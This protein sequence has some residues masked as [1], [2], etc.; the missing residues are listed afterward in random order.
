MLGID[1]LDD[2]LL[3]A[4]TLTLTK[5]FHTDPMYERIFPGPAERSGALSHL[6]RVGLRY[7]LRRGHVTQSDAA[8]AVAIWMPPC[9]SVTP[10]GMI[11]AGMLAIPFRVGFRPFGRFIGAINVMEE[12]HKR[13]VSEPHWY[14][15]IIGVDTELQGQGRGA[16]LVKEGLDLADRE[17][18]RCYLETTQERNLRFYERLGF[19]VA[20]SARLD[21]GGPEVWAM[22]RGTPNP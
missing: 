6:L 2:H 13:R 15:M 17:A 3:D 14:L 21:A 7:G 20:E 9:R 8:K 22:L 12:I 5:A 19:K 10:G 18:L 4:A 16:A 1:R 11:R